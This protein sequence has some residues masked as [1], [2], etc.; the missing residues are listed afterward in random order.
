YAVDVGRGLLHWK[1]RT[2]E[3]VVVREGVNARL[4]SEEI[5]PEPLDI[6]V[7]DV[8]FISCTKILPAADPLMKEDA[9]AFIL[10]KP[11]FE[12]PRRLAPPGGVIA[13]ENVRQDCLK[14]VTQFVEENLFWELLDVSDSPLKGPKGN[15]EFVA[16]F[17]KK[18][19]SDPSGK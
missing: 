4:L 10:V 7:M 1:L 9:L 3:R 11:Q 15:R 5:I 2:D 14:K 13:D 8:S 19:L 6:L 18:T 17:R 16:L 12:A